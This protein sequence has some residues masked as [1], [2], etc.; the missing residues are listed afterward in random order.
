MVTA[1]AEPSRSSGRGGS[2][3][4]WRGDALAAAYDEDDETALA[5]KA[6]GRRPVVGD[7]E[8][9]RATAFLA[10]RGFSARA[11]WAAVKQAEAEAAGE[12]PPDEV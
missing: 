10:R 8:R 2:P 9:R 12:Q 1:A 7:A 6:L 3:G 5:R 4:R 11:A